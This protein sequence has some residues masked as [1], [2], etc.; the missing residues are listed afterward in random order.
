MKKYRMKMTNAV[1]TALWN[2][3]DLNGNNNTTNS[4]ITQAMFEREVKEFDEGTLPFEHELY[5]GERL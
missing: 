2:R 5:I 1:S 3:V 4:V